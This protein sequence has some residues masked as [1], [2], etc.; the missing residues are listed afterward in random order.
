MLRGPQEINGMVLFSRNYRESDKL[1]KIFT[2]SNGKKMFFVRHA[3]KKNSQIS[4]AVQPFTQANY[5][6]E[7]KDEGLS[8]LNTAKDIHPFFSIQQDIFLSAYATYI[9]NLSDAA[10]EDNVYDPFLFGFLKD[11]LTLINEGYDPEIITNIFEIQILQRFGIQLNFSSCAICGS[12]E[13]PFDF[14]DKY[15]GVLCQKHWSM[16]ERRFHY[17]P[18]ALHF[19]KLFNAISYEQIKS[20]NLSDETKQHIRQV[21]DSIYE[22][23][24][25]LHLKSKKFI[26]DMQNWKEMIPKR[27]NKID[28]LDNTN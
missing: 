21:I 23:Y 1:V 24:V 8:F 27:E 2:E 19:I 13:E 10:I 9:L 6:G 28:K 17:S 20:I 7:L 3:N 26:D 14:S 12:Q 25:G 16:D 22:E 18:R 15:H 4:S 11:S 5:I